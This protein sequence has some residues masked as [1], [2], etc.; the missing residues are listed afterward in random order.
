MGV[1]DEDEGR[2]SASTST[3]KSLPSPTQCRASWPCRALFSQRCSLGT[4]T[5]RLC[6]GRDREDLPRRIETWAASDIRLRDAA[7][8]HLDEA[9]GLSAE[10]CGRIAGAL[11]SPTSERRSRC[12]TER[13]K[14]HE[15][16]QIGLLYTESDVRETFD[17][18]LI[19]RSTRVAS[20]AHVNAKLVVL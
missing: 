16:Q 12:A 8:R 18:S 13:T 1:V 3:C 2:G 11:C 6:G 17:R 4:L 5:T 7:Q 20:T 14:K 10:S 9:V 15:L 19:T